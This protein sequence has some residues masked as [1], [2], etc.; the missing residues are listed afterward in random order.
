M[1]S[2]FDAAIQAFEP[3]LPLLV[4]FSGGADSTALLMASAARWPAQVRALHV[5]HGLQPAADDFAR[6]C[7]AFCAA[8]QVPLTVRR[9]HARHAPGESPEDAARIARHA[10]FM[11]VSQDGSAQ[12]AIKS[13]A[14]AHHADDQVETLLLALTR[15]AGL[16]GLSA[17]PAAWQRDGLQFH[18]P[19]LAVHAA[20]IRAWLAERGVAYLIDPSNSDERYTRNRIRARLLPA[21]DQAF[22]QF[23]ETFARSIGHAAQAQSLLDE[24]AAQDL[25]EVGS[26]PAIR[27]LQALSGARQANLLRHWLKASHATMPSAAQLQEVLRQVAACTTRGHHIELKVGAGR[28]VR[29]GPVLDWYNP[30]ALPPAD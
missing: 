15:G 22:P 27:R 11:A 25:A 10:A 2:A 30:G 1:R 9:V 4:G 16:P 20:D 17:M 8:L 23:R 18:R 19:L 5:H 14:L 21:L 3:A 7:E 13:I 28:L 24:L 29:R 6:H 12:P 26:P